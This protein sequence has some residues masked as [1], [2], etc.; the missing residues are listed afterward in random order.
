[1]HRAHG[2]RKTIKQEGHNSLCPYKNNQINVTRRGVLQYAPTI[3][4]I[5]HN[6]WYENHKWEE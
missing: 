2:K 6:L 5:N 3:W 4:L 1:M